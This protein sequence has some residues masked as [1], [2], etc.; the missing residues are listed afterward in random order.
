MDALKR[1]ARRIR[2]SKFVRN[3]AL[4]A[5]GTAGAQLI[6]AAFAPLLTRQYGPAAYGVLGAFLAIVAVM[7]NIAGMTY[8]IAMVLPQEDRKAR[9]LALLAVA[10]AAVFAV[11]LAA[12]VWQMGPR[13]ESWVSMPGVAGL[14]L[15]LPLTVL[16]TTMLSASRQW[17]IRR[18]MFK[19]IAA[20]GVAQAF[21][22][23]G[24]KA[25]V[26]VLAASAS[27]LVTIS[28]LAPALY[29]LFMSRGLRELIDSGEKPLARRNRLHELRQVAWE[30]RDFPKYRAPQHLLNSF[31]LAVPTLL[32]AGTYGARAAGFYAITQTVMGLPSVLI[33]KAVGDVFYPRV[34][35]TIREGKAADGEISKATGAL[36]VAGLLPFGVIVVAGPELFAFVFGAEWEQAGQYARW[37]APF[38]LLNLANKP[39]VV[40]IAPLGLQGQLLGYEVIATTMKCAGFLIG[41]YW[42]RNDIASVALFSGAGT[43]AYAALVFYVIAKAR[44][45]RR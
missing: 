40:A 31:G 14:I 6:V 27:A 26:G 11:L 29:I 37:L 16:L 17:L 38:Y 32:L 28:A 19:T 43:V 22:V 45:V 13:V 34:S 21:V 30:Y 1:H 20:A 5:G 9:N 41:F 12:A 42:I 44:K 4:V 33:G 10:I 23:N 24:V 15:L 25:G 35:A 7:T 8:P 36:L 2:H 3:V 39:S 18:G